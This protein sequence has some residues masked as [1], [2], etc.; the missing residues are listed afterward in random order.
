M[1]F[2]VIASLKSTVTAKVLS[3]TSATVISASF[4]PT[5]V[6]VGLIVSISNSPSGV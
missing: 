6:T 5:L 3:P 2:V 4:T 1:P